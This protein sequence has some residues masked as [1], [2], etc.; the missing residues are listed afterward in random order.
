VG[1]RG[2]DVRSRK[3]WRQKVSDAMTNLVGERLGERERESVCVGMRGWARASAG[4]L[5]PLCDTSIVTIA[6]T[7]FKQ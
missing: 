7:M 6:V 1:A 5:V 2:V 3:W 4:G